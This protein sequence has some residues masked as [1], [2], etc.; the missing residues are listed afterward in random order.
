MIAPI[1]FYLPYFCLQYATLLPFITPRI[2]YGYAWSRYA[3][4]I[5]RV[6]GKKTMYFDPTGEQ[7]RK[8]RTNPTTSPRRWPG[9]MDL[10]LPEECGGGGSAARFR[11]NKRTEEPENNT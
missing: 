9:L 11:K 2:T 5:E 6:P 8:P 1:V 4:T 10:T 7:T 3:A